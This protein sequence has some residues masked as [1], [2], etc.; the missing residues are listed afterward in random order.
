M[1]FCSLIHSLIQKPLSDYSVQGTM[2]ATENTTINK[3]DTA[4]AFMEF[5]F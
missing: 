1:C 3:S 4:P 5:A 2:T